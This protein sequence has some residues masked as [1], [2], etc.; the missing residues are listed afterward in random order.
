M[1]RRA[2]ILAPAKAT[3]RV[4]KV[5]TVPACPSIGTRCSPHPTPGFS[6]HDFRTP[7]PEPE[8]SGGQQPARRLSS[9]AAPFRHYSPAR[10]PFKPP[11]FVATR[12]RSLVR[13]QH[14]PS[15]GLAVPRRSSVLRMP[16]EAV[17][18][19]ASP[20]ASTS[21]REDRSGPCPAPV[22]SSTVRVPPASGN[23]SQVPEC[24]QAPGNH[25]RCPAPGQ[26]SVSRWPAAR[27][28]RA[29]SPAMARA[30]RMC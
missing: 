3:H 8:G 29:R 27:G 1:A 28:D 5:L 14:R 2:S 30:S 11:R 24:P 22:R 23:Q 20:R 25:Q 6:S 9:F 15:S 12:R 13:A 18:V 10:H 19:T 21:V 16:T 4:T 7:D 17:L 26:Q